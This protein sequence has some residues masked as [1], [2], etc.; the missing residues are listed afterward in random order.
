MHH[1]KMSVYN[2]R[3]KSLLGIFTAKL[4]FWRAS[5]QMFDPQCEYITNSTKALRAASG[6]AANPENVRQPV[7]TK[8]SRC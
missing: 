5:M 2:Y 7:R 8:R 4:A 1:T 6:R 3:S